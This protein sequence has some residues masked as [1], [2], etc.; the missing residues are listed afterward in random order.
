[1]Y[2]THIP[3]QLIALL[4]AHHVRTV[5]FCPETNNLLLLNKLTAD[6]YFTCY[7]IKN[8]LTAAYFAIGLS[9][10]GGHSIAVCCGEKSGLLYLQP[11]IVE[12]FH[13]QVPLLVLSTTMLS[14]QN[15]AYPNY[16]NNETYFAPIAS[17]TKKQVHLFPIH[18]PQE[19]EVC[20]RWINE[21]L[22]ELTR[23]GK[24]PVHI[25]FPISEEDF[26]TPQEETRPTRTINYFQ[27]LNDYDK[28][29][30]ELI[31]RLNKYNRRMVV[32]GQTHQIYQFE[33]RIC[34]MLYK[35]F[36]WLAEH[37]SNQT[38]PGMPIK[39]F[40]SLLASLPQERQTQ[41]IPEL[42]ITYGGDILS[43]SLKEWLQT[44][45]PKEHWHISLGG[46]LPT[47]FGPKIIHIEMDPFEFL[48]KIAP[49]LG[50]NANE[51]PRQWEY[52]SKKQTPPSFPFS[53]MGIIG[54]LL[55]QLPA[56]AALHLAPGSIHD[57]AQ[58][59][60]IPKETEVCSNQGLKN[61]QGCLTTALGY[62]YT[63]D[64]TNFI[65][66]GDQSFSNDIHALQEIPLRPNVRILLL[67]NQ[68]NEQ[69]TRRASGICTHD[70]SRQ[71]IRQYYTT[72]TAE[73]TEKA[74]ISYTA[75]HS[76]DELNALLPLFTSPEES[77]SPML[78]EAFTHIDED[79]NLLDD[80]LQKLPTEGQPT[81]STM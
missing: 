65:I 14:P 76:D 16:L 12:A 2:P 18:S 63:S 53:E 62:A 36:V 48:E 15:F 11:A 71:M 75:V 7:S 19:E 17:V 77:A 9:L 50:N 56:Q 38:I 1:M 52:Y 59:F 5:V 3:S 67:N 41:L 25:S 28:P 79:L 55:S 74:G 44:N 54:R 21:A 31:E 4:K 73:Q 58:L 51:Y 20:N 66:L 29:Y 32:V 81:T 33:R 8:P 40:A 22:I 46:K 57:Y 43:T 80:Y 42:L 24:G 23:H 27:G 68:G 26:S 37:T 13:Q 70:K 47:L 61:H 34:K 78:I 64:R 49:L 30:G 6:P 45:P 39:N 69:L 72:Q 10:N 35:H 60:S